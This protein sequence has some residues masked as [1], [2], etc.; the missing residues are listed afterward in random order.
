M[1][2]EIE[3]G[4]LI[5][6]IGLVPPG[7]E[8]RILRTTSFFKFLLDPSPFALEF[9]PGDIAYA[10]LSRKTEDPKDEGSVILL[11]EDIGFMERNAFGDLREYPNNQAFLHALE[12][13]D[14]V[15]VAFTQRLQQ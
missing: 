9:H 5:D 13:F 2:N 3:A 8:G 4:L 1:T 14:Q 7:Q 6:E 10:T 12:C 15:K 11:K